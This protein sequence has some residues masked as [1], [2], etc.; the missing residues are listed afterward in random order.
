MNIINL[1]PHIITLQ[2]ADGSRQDI[3]A[4]GTVARVATV[5]GQLLS[6]NC[7]VPVYSATRFGEVEGL[8]EPLANTVYLVSAMVAA[9]MEG[10]GRTDVLS[11]GTGPQDGAIR[12]N[13]Q[14]V[15][16][17]RLIQAPQ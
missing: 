4:S 17:T 3:L 7:P 13:G 5:P 10:R 16:V 11:P 6:S 8:P 1:T 2:L 15:A 14:I 9:R 12:E